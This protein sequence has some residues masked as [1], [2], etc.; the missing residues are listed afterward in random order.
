MAGRTVR[1]VDSCNCLQDSLADMVFRRLDEYDLGFE[2]PN[3]GLAL[4]QQVPL[5]ALSTLFVERCN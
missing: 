3:T 5:L 2:D 4:L 1:S